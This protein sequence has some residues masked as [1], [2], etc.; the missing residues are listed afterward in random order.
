VSGATIRLARGGDAQ[1]MP[2]LC[3]GLSQVLFNDPY[4]EMP[5]PSGCSGVLAMGG[6]CT[7]G[8]GE[9]DVIDGVQ[10]RRIREG[11]ITFSNGFGGCPF[12][13]ADN[14]AEI[15]THELG[16]AIGIGHSSEEDD[17]PSAVRKDAT[18]YYR[19][20]FDGRAA[21]VRPDDIAAVRAL[22]P[23]G[24]EPPDPD[25]DRDGV[26]DAADNCPGDDP[27]LGLENPA[28]TDLD[29]DGRGDVCDP[30]P[31]AADDA[32]CGQLLASRIRAHARRDG[33]LS[34][35]AVVDTPVIDSRD[36]L[37]R[38]VLVSADG[39]LLDSNAVSARSGRGRGEAPRFVRR[40]VFRGTN[41]T[42]SLGRGRRAGFRLRMK[43]RP[44]V[45]PATPVSLLSVNLQVGDHAYTA[46]LICRPSRHALACS[47]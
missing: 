14:L 6:Y 31:L 10:Y 46:P 17:E 37:A 20:H 24:D 39:V 36:T 28:Q 21:S 38:V 18:M 32:S 4:G 45:A 47:S 43:V 33:R 23:G 12:W 5:N 29:G 13:T 11:N 7:A 27:L 22:Y 15:A 42:L 35:A 25:L 1:S 9:V 16:H 26:P 40:Q 41:A 8:L 44:F 3:D 2:M 34:W 19:A 30:C